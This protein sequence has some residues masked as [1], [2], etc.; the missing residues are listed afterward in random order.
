ML[1]VLA[2]VF[3]IAILVAVHEYGHYGA[4]LLCGVKVLRFSIG[5]GPRLFGWTSAKSGTEFV[6]CLLPLGGYVK[7]VDGREGPVAEE[8]QGKAFNVQPLRSRVAIVSAGPLANLLFAVLLYA[9]VNWSGVEQAQPILSKPPANSIAAAAGIVGGERVQRAGFEGEALQD[10][11]SFEDFRWWITRG[12]L[13]QR[14]IQVE[15]GLSGTSADTAKTLRTVLVLDGIDASNAD[16]KMFQGIG[17]VGPYSKAVLGEL[18]ADGAAMQAGLVP[19]DEVLQVDQT[20]IV[21]AGQLRA[22]IRDSGQTGSVGAQQWTVNRGGILQGFTVV[23]RLETLGDLKVGRVGA[24]IGVQPALVTVRFGF[25]EGLDRALT[26]TWDVSVL[27]LKMMGKILTGDA[28]LQ[29][30]SGPL[31][32][33]DYAGKSASMGI[34]P[35]L[36]FLALISISLGVLNLLPLPVLDGGHLMYYLWESLTGK[37]VSEAWLERL[38]RVGLVVLMMMMS[39]A[40]FNDFARLL[41]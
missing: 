15:F 6:V 26:R 39:V 21:D 38:Q 8:D 37:P 22:L 11:A 14:N 34:T 40:V 28:S 35:F 13:A 33:A 4:A 10:V 23:P 36:I 18:A 41:G 2:F 20:V 29:N 12:A 7:M 27:T 5:F 9:G 25:L 30:L 1:T 32:I 31:T 3:A 24:F 16:A 19:G 17:V